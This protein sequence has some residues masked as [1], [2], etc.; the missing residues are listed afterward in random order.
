MWRASILMRASITRQFPSCGMDWCWLATPAA[1][2]EASDISA[3]STPRLASRCGIS[4]TCL[5]LAR[6]QRPGPT[7]LTTSRQAAAFIHPFALDPDAGLVYAPVGN[8]GPDFVKDYRP[9]DNLYTCGVVELD[10]K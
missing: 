7:I 5:P 10:A 8:P 3:R 1:I 6:R 2:W 4:T 9:G